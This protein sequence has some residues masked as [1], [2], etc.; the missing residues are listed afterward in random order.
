MEGKTD[1][2][3]GQSWKPNQEKA[4]KREDSGFIYYCHSPGIR[5]LLGGSL[6]SGHHLRVKPYILM[7]TLNSS[8]FSPLLLARWLVWLVII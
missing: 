2:K 3:T 7:R 1:T 5:Y 4:G 6:F 8:A